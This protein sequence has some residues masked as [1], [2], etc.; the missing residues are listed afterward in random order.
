M[1]DELKGEGNQGNRKLQYSFKVT[2]CSN[3]YI[4][5]SQS[6]CCIIHIHSLARNQNQSTT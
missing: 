5:E 4:N 2:S 6:K 3:L 1:S